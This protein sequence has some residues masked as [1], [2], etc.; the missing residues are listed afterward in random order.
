M[1]KE[2]LFRALA[3]LENLVVLAIPVWQH[4]ISDFPW[5]SKPLEKTARGLSVLVDPS[6]PVATAQSVCPGLKLIVA[7]SRTFK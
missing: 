1:C 2:L 4:L 3:R 6:T 5:P 7:D